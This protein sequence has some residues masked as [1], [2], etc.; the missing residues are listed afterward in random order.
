MDVLG[1][2]RVHVV[3]EA[4]TGIVRIIRQL[5]ESGQI[6]LGRGDEDAFVA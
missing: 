2:V 4:Q 6:I 5:E 1:P 3:E